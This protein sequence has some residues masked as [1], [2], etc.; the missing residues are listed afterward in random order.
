MVP[1]A[2]TCRY[3]AGE[4]ARRSR[5]L[6]RVLRPRVRGLCGPVVESRPTLA[7]VWQSYERRTWMVS[8][9]DPADFHTGIVVDVY[10]PLRGSVSDP[11][12][13][14]RR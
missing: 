6:V 14:E 8:V 5:D 7:E 1:S 10:G 13:S 9:T 3:R 4:V 11:R 12:I 2:H